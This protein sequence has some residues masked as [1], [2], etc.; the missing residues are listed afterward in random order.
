MI[1][2]LSKECF[3]LYF[4]WEYIEISERNHKG[5]H[6]IDAAAKA[7]PTVLSGINRKQPDAF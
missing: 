2:T 7:I 5:W 1:A 6:I 4:F 3:F